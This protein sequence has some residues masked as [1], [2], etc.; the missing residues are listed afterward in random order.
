MSILNRI[1]HAIQR[2]K[3]QEM[4]NRYGFYETIETYND[5]L[6]WTNAPFGP[7]TMPS[8]HE[9][10]EFHIHTMLDCPFLIKPRDESLTEYSC[11]LLLNSDTY[12]IELK[13]LVNFLENLAD[14]QD[15]PLLQ[16]PHLDCVC[17]E[18]TGHIS[19]LQV[20]ND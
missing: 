3:R 7:E 12:N 6:I 1:R 13:D 2:G 8:K 16:Y 15:T 10:I 20:Q 14:W 4:L 5:T 9:C 18:W 17:M 19:I 11:R